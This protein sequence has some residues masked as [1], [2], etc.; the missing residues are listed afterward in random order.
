M[1]K[2]AAVLAPLTL[3]LSACA[4]TGTTGTAPSTATTSNSLAMMAVKVGVQATCVT[5]LNNNTYWKTGSKLLT[6][7]QK[8]ELQTEVC[9]C[10]GEKATTSVT[11]TD[12]VV[13]AM[14]KTS[15][16]NLAAKIVTNTLNACVVETLKN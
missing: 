8:S 11:A 3:V 2:L 4:A 9:S 13:A 10:V 16:A 12:L 5:E 14:D 6:E 15:Q 7:T 1:K